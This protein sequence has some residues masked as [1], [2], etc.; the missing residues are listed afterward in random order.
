MLSIK[1]IFQSRLFN[2][3]FNQFLLNGFSY[4]IPIMLIPYLI[5]TIGIDKYGLIS[6]IL[7]FSLYFQIINEWGF[8]LSN[9]RH[10]VANRDKIENLSNI[11]SSILQSKVIIFFCTTI[12][13]SCVVIAIPE[14]RTEWLLYT[15]AA[16]RMFGIILTPTWFFRSMEDVKYITRII[17][18]VKLISIFPIFFIVKSP[19]DCHWVMFF[20]TLETLLSATI[21][22]MIAIRRYRISLRITALRSVKFYMYDSMPFFTSTMLQSIYQASNTIVLKF[23]CGDYATGIYTA[24]EKL[25]NSYASFASPLISHILYPYFTR[26]K[27]FRIINRICAYVV[28]GNVVV[29]FLIYLLAPYFITYFIKEGAADVTEYFLIFLFGIIV[30]V[31]SI[32]M[33]YPYLGVMGYVN[34]VN[35]ITAYA[36]TFYIVGVI[37]LIGC[38]LVTILSLIVLLILTQTLSLAMKLFFIYKLKRTNE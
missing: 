37:V 12:I 14:L 26:I 24:A 5:K 4:I 22:L 10:I 33:G 36:C 31:P 6:F 9:V 28:S 20:Y 30:S 34:L 18:P 11:V 38:Q 32:L 7:A 23:F 3:T 19:L 1:N 21:S 17:V 29:V 35:K 16:I 27:D 13:Y 2:N 25:H 8:D 15:F